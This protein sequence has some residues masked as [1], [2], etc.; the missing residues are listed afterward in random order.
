[1]D[2]RCKIAVVSDFDGTISDDDFF[3]YITEQYLT[4]A[5]MEPWR[6]YLAGCKTHFEALREIFAKL[7]VDEKQL[8]K[9]ICRIH[10]DKTFADTAALCL[11]QSLPLYI[12]SAGCD[13][14]INLLI[15]NWIKEYK[16]KL[17]TNHAVYNEQNG[18]QMTP[19]DKNSLYYDAEIGVSKPRVVEILQQLGYFVV[20]CGDGIPDLGAAQIADKV[21]ARKILLEKCRNAGIAAEEFVCFNQ[22]THFIEEKLA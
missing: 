3:Y 11:E 17:V 20:Y 4:P 2:V 18:L 22:V 13:Y 6:Q 5:D 21:F 16:I 15:G 9:F 8:H 10:I 12:C 14:Y 19:P 1:M 7:R